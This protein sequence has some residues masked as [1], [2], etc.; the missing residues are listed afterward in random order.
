MFTF[1]V[2]YKNQIPHHKINSKFVSCYSCV[3]KTNKTTEYQIQIRFSCATEKL[4]RLSQNENPT[5][6]QT[7]YL[8]NSFFFKIHKI[9]T[10]LLGFSRE[11]PSLLFTDLA[12]DVAIITLSRK[13]TVVLYKCT[14]ASRVLS[15]TATKALTRY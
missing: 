14:V 3:Q 10:F 12:T 5:N 11:M 13:R 6:N 4:H 15:N 8:Y 1:S 2:S 9:L 7:F